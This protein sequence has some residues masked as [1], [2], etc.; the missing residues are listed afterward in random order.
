MRQI[1]TTLGGNDWQR[2]HRATYRRRLTQLERAGIRNIADLIANMPSLSTKTLDWVIQLCWLLKVK[3][4]APVLWQLMARPKLRMA[5]AHAMGFLAVNRF[6]RKFAKLGQMELQNP[7]PDIRQLEVIVAGL[8]YAIGPEATEVMVSIF[9]RPDLPGWIR[10]EVGDAIPS[11]G[12]VGKR[13]SKSFNRTVK[14]AIAGLDDSD[15]NM[16]FWSMYALGSLACHYK[17]YPKPSINAIFQPA[18]PKLREIAATDT[19]LAPGYWWPMSA[20]AEDAIG[21]IE[22]GNWPQPD[23]GERWPSTGPRG[24]WR[25]SESAPSHIELRVERVAERLAYVA[26]S[27]RD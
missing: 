4:A 14:A 6:E 2:A 3:Q 26:Q 18:L 7:R 15:I 25:C 9:E 16:Q 19:R 13:R 23:A 17:R 10:G 21:C 20:E 22:T 5:C 27:L 8:R 1:A 11:I 24:E 12:D